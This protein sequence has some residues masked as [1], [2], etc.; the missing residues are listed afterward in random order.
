[1]IEDYL[2]QTGYNVSRSVKEL[3][4]D[5]S[6]ST[7]PLT[8]S[9]PTVNYRLK[10]TLSGDDCAGTITVNTTE[11]LAFTTAG[12]KTTTTTLTANTLPTV[13][14]AN[15]SCNI[16]IE[17]IDVGGQ[18]IYEET[19]ISIYCKFNDTQASFRDSSGQWAT[20]D[21][22]AYVNDGTMKIG[23]VFSYG[24]Y[25]YDVEK[26]SAHNDLDGEEE[27][28]KLYLTGMRTAPSG[29]TTTI[30]AAS[31]VIDEYMLK[32]EYDVG[33]NGIVDQAE[34]LKD[35]ATVDGGE[36]T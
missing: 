22:I 16:L 15:L 6:A 3:Y 31:P 32:S 19:Q 2:N 29:R 33:D 1:M 4:D 9:A 12:T 5:D 23:S 17:C 30:T 24:G 28:R 10:I 26:F 25:D 27:F 11:T 8:G 34:S 14:T 20:S 21:A 36:I 13:T 18:P 7:L 35:G